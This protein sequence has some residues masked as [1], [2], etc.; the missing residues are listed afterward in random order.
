MPLRLVDRDRHIHVLQYLSTSTI[1]ACVRCLLPLLLRYDFLYRTC[2]LFLDS[3]MLIAITFL[4][5]L[6]VDFVDFFEIRMQRNLVVELQQ[7][8]SEIQSFLS[9]KNIEIKLHLDSKID[10][11]CYK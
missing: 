1:I 10:I 4:H 11:D 2:T 5:F 7:L 9:D 6:E 3:V 8:I